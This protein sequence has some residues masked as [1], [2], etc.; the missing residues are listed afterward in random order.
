VADQEPGTSS[1]LTAASPQPLVLALVGL[2][3]AG[4]STAVQL[5]QERLNAEVVYFGGL[6]VDR[7]RELGLPPGESSERTVREDW[8]A[9]HGMGALAVAAGPRIEAHV[10]QRRP[11][12]IDGLYSWAELEWLQARFPLTTVAVHADRALRESRVATRPRRPLTAA[13]LRSR[14]LAEAEHLDKARPIALADH[15]VVNNGSPADLRVQIDR[16]LASV[17]PRA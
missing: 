16:V 4:K 3:G 9:R 12:I 5:C 17:S 11:V 2:P 10:A 6:V 7:V 13:E 14:D 15:H 8:R 1:P